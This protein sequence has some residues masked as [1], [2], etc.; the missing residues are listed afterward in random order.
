MRR[1]IVEAVVDAVLLFV[2]FV[3]LNFITVQQPFPFGTSS[4]P[5]IESRGAGIV[6][7]VT[8]PPSWCSSTDSHGRCSWR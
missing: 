5:I 1:F 7:F 8:G 6:G 4:A 2:I 3:V